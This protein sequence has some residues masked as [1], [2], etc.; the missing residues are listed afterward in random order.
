MEPRSRLALVAIPHRYSSGD[1]VSPLGLHSIAAYLENNAIDIEVKI[2]DFSYS[3]IS[4]TVACEEI[5][6]WKPD[7]VGISAYSNYVDI[8]YNYGKLINSMATDVVLIAGGPHITL[9]PREFL[10]EEACRFDIAIAGDGEKP[11]LQLMRIINDYEVSK[12]ALLDTR[13]ID[14]EGLSYRIGNGIIHSTDIICRLQ[15]NE[16]ENPLVIRANDN[17]NLVEFRGLGSK[18]SLKGVVLISSRS[19][20]YRCSF[21]SITAID[22]KKNQ[23]RALEPEIIIEWLK[24]ARK[25]LDF[26]HISFLDANF[27]VRR[28]RVLDFSKLLYEEFQGTLTWSAS[29]TVGYIINLNDELPLLYKQGLRKVEIGIEAGSQRQLDFFI[30]HSRVEQ[31]YQAVKILKQNNIQLGLDFIMFYHDQTPLDIK[32][33]LLFIHGSCLTEYPSFDH[34]YNILLLY[35]GT[36]ARSSLE[37]ELGLKFKP[38]EIP[39]SRNYIK[40]PIVKK[41]YTSYIDGFIKPYLR[42]IE[43]S[44]INIGEE[45]SDAN[46]SSDNKAILSLLITALRHVPFKALWLLVENNGDIESLDACLQEYNAIECKY[47]E[48]LA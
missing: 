11:V 46:V 7:V 6:S 5:L 26:K 27:F 33:N 39:S 14:I 18:D 29:S 42:E 32:E 44:I 4:D 20:P 15:G 24:E 19:C 3:Q 22:G 25:H 12:H 41:I 28:K 37:Q 2:F 30:K 48:L 10:L 40:D 47:K 13:V 16:W 38:N 31:N 21:C 34:L 1:I 8:V 23:W 17:I 43:S 9:M 45:I 35:P 36:A